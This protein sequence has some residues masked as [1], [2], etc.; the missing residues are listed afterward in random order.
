MRIGLAHQT[1]EKKLQ[2]ENSVSFHWI[3]TT[4]SRLFTRSL[5]FNSFSFEFLFVLYQ[6][7]FA[8]VEIIQI[9]IEFAFKRTTTK[10]K[11]FELF[12]HLT[13]NK[14]VKP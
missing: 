2:S 13:I 6:S 4:I 3:E 9:S 7:L 10:K 14:M 12:P 5:I 8:S 1:F 11:Q